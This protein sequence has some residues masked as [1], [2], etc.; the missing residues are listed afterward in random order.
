MFPT[1]TVIPCQEH[2]RQILVVANAVENHFASFL[3][4]AT[5]SL[6]PAA[7]IVCQYCKLS[8]LSVDHVMNCLL[9]LLAEVN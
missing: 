2:L 3:Q 7:I 6:F 5:S 8:A 1:A 9:Q 4:G